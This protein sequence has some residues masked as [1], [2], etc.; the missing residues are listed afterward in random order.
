MPT[1]QNSG[2]GSCGPSLRST[3]D[4]GSWLARKCVPEQTTPATNY[5]IGESR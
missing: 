4:F 5:P 1:Y 3:I 2:T